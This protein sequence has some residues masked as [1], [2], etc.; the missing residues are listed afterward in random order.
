M[1]LSLLAG[2]TG[3]RGPGGVYQ[4]LYFGLSLM[5]N[6]CGLDVF[7]NQGDC[8]FYGYLQDVGPVWQQLDPNKTLFGPNIFVVP[9]D[10]K[11]LCA[12]GK[13]FVVP[14]EW[15]K[16]LY[17]KYPEMNGKKIHVWSAGIDTKTWRPDV[18]ATKDLDCFIYFKNREQSEL[19]NVKTQLDS[20][21][22]KYEVIGYGTYHEK[23]LKDLC[24]R[25]RF[26]VL[27]TG[28]ESQGLAYMQILSMNVPCYVLNKTTWTS[29]NGLV[30]VP[31]SSVPYFTN[32]CG[33]IADGLDCTGIN[34]FKN[35]LGNY[36]PRDYILREHGFLEKAKAYAEL[37]KSL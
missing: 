20:M 24:Y 11:A 36:K 9:S 26:A 4:N 37:I 6:Y 23:A 1:K 28:T 19:D 12:H 25:S 16:N 13:H 3:H 10:N 34:E 22:L 17:E 5:R 21:G 14:S 30:T 32:E 33:V 2:N 18:N 15:V 31:A 8:D 27:L 7:H 35:N 29:D